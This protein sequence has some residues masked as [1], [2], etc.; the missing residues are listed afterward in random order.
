MDGKSSYDPSVD[1]S[2]SVE[3]NGAAFRVH[4]ILPGRPVFLETPEE[5][6]HLFRN[7][8]PI[9]NDRMSAFLDK[10]ANKAG[11]K[12]DTYFPNDLTIWMYR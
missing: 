12:H 10:M 5:L 4:S 1:P 8:I 7:S 11:E 2:I 9:Y 3:F 6:Q